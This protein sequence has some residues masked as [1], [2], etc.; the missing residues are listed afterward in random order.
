MKDERVGEGASVGS[1]DPSMEGVGEGCVKRTKS[2]I[3]RDRES[4]LGR[5][6]VCLSSGSG[7]PPVGA[8][9]EGGSVEPEN[10]EARFLDEQVL[11]VSGG[12][13]EVEDALARFWGGVREEDGSDMM[14]IFKKTGCWNI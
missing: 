1:K 10:E 11:R 2:S 14:S 3:C 5:A 9:G 4:K 8:T 13:R 12:R 6:I 7:I